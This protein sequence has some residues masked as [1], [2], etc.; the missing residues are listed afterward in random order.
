MQNPWK[1]ILAFVGVFIAGAVF[2]GL[3]ALRLGRAITGNRPG[4]M[5]PARGEKMA[6]READGPAAANRPGGP[7]AVQRVQLMR[8]LANQLDLSPAQRE[9]IGPIINR[10]LQDFWREQQ[11]F[12]R[13]NVFHLQRLKQDIARELQPEQQKRLD[14]LWQKQTEVL[15]RRQS[16]AQTQRQAAARA[17]AGDAKLVPPEPAKPA[18]GSPAK[19]AADPGK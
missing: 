14:E 3:L 6:G 10:A 16:E 5:A 17:G 1:V 9:R 7:P 19:P 2:G 15:R 18:S 4:I 11:N 13:E 12:A 8:R